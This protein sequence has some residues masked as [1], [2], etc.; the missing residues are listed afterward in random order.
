MSGSFET[1]NQGWYLIKVK[2]REELRA[3]EN[4][5]YQGFEAYCPTY[6][7]SGR[8]AIL[9]PGYVFVR[10][11]S[12]DLERYHKIRSTRGVS[13]I[14]TFNLMY[15]E[16]F[17][18]G[19][20]KSPGQNDLQKLLPQPIPNGEAIIHQIEEIIWALNGGK[21]EEKPKYTAFNEGD[22]VRINNSLFKHLKS[23]FIKGINVDRGLVLIE[24]IKSQRV[25]DDVVKTSVTRRKIEVPMEELEKV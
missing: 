9:F 3:L 7:E 11:C 24:F 6:L 20:I 13:R 15:K 16:H 4:L 2:S 23:T 5:E 10:L 21:A 1:I 18:R 17:E 25:D 19:H 14:V 8:D 12:K 22:K